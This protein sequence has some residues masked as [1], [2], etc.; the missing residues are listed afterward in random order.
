MLRIETD[1]TNP[2]AAIHYR[3]ILEAL[4]KRLLPASLQTSQW[5]DHDIRL[6]EYQ[7]WHSQLPVVTYDPLPKQAPLNIHIYCLWH[8]R[9]YALRFIYD[10]ISRWLCPGMRA[11]ITAFL[12]LDFKLPDINEDMYTVCQIDVAL[13]TTALLNDAA[14]TLPTLS[15]ELRL[16]IESMYH[17]WRILEVK[18]LHVDDKATLIQEQISYLIKRK[19]HIF[20][21]ELIVEMQHMLVMCP[22]DF[23][24]KRDSHHLSRLISA[25]YMFRKLIGELSANNPEQRHLRLKIYRYKCYRDQSYRHILGILVTINFTNDKEVFEEKHLMRALQN[26]INGI[27]IVE[28]SVFINRYS[29][30]H[31]CSLYLEVE[32]ENGSGFTTAEHALLKAELPY[33]LKDRIEHLMHPVFMPRNE[34]EI[35]RN[36]LNLSSQIK[37]ANDQPQAF[38]AFDEQMRDSLIFTVILV[39]VSEPGETPLQEKILQSNTHLE[40]I[41]DR[42][43]MIGML[44]KRYVKEAHVFR[45]K[46]SKKGFIRENGAIDLNKARQLVVD[47]M[48][49]IIGEFRDYNGGM[50]CK[51]NEL[52]YSL[53]NC[54][55]G[56]KYSDLM[57]ENFF[58]ALMPIDMRALLDSMT[59][60][61]LFIML[62]EVI[63]EGLFKIESILFRSRKHENIQL[64]IASVLSLKAK[65]QLLNLASSLNLKNDSLVYSYIHVYD[66]PYFCYILRDL[67]PEQ[68]Q[69]VSQH[70]KQIIGYHSIPQYTQTDL[71]ANI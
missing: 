40:Y 68:Q 11:N 3:H 65:E 63:D 35:L 44:R 70:I 24:A 14:R 7:R 64:I 16:G 51:Q 43:K 37:F 50:I 27:K 33:D 18:G 1:F 58:Y 8:H 71:F 47:E 20:D 59:L 19:P 12:S 45:L 62:L 21:Q 49:A 29:S 28:G 36:I 10:M 5:N 54:L 30:A 42:C 6:Q 31:M 46:F 39:R 41:P 9:P 25:Q 2:H 56:I 34:E 66:V 15:T 13:P 61:R 23:I 69:L 52:L 32:K 53:R 57:L 26:Y 48:T 55:K 38:I 4:L 22:A 60:A 67:T 17:A